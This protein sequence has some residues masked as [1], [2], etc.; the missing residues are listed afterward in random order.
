MD[1]TSGWMQLQLSL[2]IPFILYPGDTELLSLS[3]QWRETERGERWGRYLNTESWLI[4]QS[5][6]SFFD[7]IIRS[8]SH[9]NPLAT[10]P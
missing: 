2:P 5:A 3:F 9:K 6:L 8:K 10:W 7:E 1:I 4:S